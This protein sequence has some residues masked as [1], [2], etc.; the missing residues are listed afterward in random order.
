MKEVYANPSYQRV[1]LRRSLLEAADIPC[2]IR[3]DTAYRVADAFGGLL[4]CFLPIPEWWP[5][6]CVIYAEDFAQAVQLLWE[7]DNGDSSQVC[8]QCGE[9]VPSSFELCWNC[10]SD[11][12]QPVRD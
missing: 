8:P 9:T 12:P 4:A 11:L 1:A 10:K 3:N 6:L 7:V 2:F 5:N